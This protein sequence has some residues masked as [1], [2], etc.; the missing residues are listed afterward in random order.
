MLNVSMT[1]GKK[2]EELDV[3]ELEGHLCDEDLRRVGQQ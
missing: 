2:Q 1:G 3:L